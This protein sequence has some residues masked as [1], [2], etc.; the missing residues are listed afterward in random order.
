MRAVEHEYRDAMAVLQSVAELR[1]VFTAREMYRYC[2]RAGEALEALADRLWY[3]VLRR[4]LQ[5][6]RIPAGG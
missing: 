4:R 5:R 6:G 3:A 1:T 2:A